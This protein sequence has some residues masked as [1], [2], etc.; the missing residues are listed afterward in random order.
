MRPDEPAS[1][2]LELLTAVFDCSL[3]INYLDSASSADDAKIEQLMRSGVR[4]EP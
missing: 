4:L 2:V 3:G 1:P